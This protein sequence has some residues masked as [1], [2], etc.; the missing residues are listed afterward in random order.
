MD[1]FQEIDKATKGS[2]RFRQIKWGIFFVG[3]S[4]FAQLYNFQP[5]L[6][7]ISS[8]FQ[9]A[10]SQSSLTVSFSTAGMALGLLIFAFIADQFER[11]KIILFALFTSTLLTLLSVGV[12]HFEL[13]LLLNFLKGAC[14]SGVSA[15]T[16]AYLAE[17]IDPT[18]IGGAISFYLA[19]NTFGGMA[20]RI[21]A[22]LIGDWL[23]WR[24]AVLAIGLLALIVAFYIKKSFPASNFF[25]PYK[26]NF[27]EQYKQMKQLFINPKITALYIVAICLM[28]SFVSVYN[29]LGF[30]LEAPPYNLP[31]SLIAC[32]FL[33]Y[34]FGIVGNLLGGTLSDKY[35]P[36]KI[37][38]TALILVLFGLILLFSN[39]L[40]ILIFGLM[41][42]TVAFFCAH[43][44]AGR[45]V[46][47]LAQ[48]NRTSA[49]ALYWFFYYMGSSI[50]GSATGYFINNN[51][52]NGFFTALII[53]VL[54]SLTAV[55]WTTRTKKT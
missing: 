53:L 18:N 40:L 11:K 39:A 13:L 19:G 38:L 27:L 28:G 51:N 21:M 2:S 16:L 10:P 29:Y 50:V 9:I 23:G 49:T 7:Q 44:L 3:V 52:W 12:M 37:L 8:Y 15:V 55:Y 20:G 25:L 26:R 34:A 36:K 48:E 46:T 30:K 1:T 24:I 54:L 32:I 22:A 41:L 5:L 31:H 6:P 43:T 14:I 35:A 47:D 45:L 4:V 17:E 33:M 42:F